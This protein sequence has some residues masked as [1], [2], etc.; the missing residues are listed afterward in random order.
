MTLEGL[1]IRMVDYLLTLVLYFF[2]KYCMQNISAVCLFIESERVLF[3]HSILRSLQVRRSY[4]LP[5]RKIRCKERNT[6]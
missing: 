6:T 2:I 4:K 5:R 3:T 1:Q